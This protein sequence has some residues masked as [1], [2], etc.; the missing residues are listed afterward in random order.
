MNAD[1]QKET[2]VRGGAALFLAIHF[3][4]AVSSF[5]AVEERLRTEIKQVMDMS[6]FCLD[7]EFHAKRSARRPIPE[8]SESGRH[9]LRWMLYVGLLDAVS[10]TTRFN[11]SRRTRCTP[12]ERCSDI[13]RKMK[14]RIE[15]VQNAQQCGCCNELATD[16][17]VPLNRATAYARQYELGLGFDTQNCRHAIATPLPRHT[18]WHGPT[19]RQ[20]QRQVNCNVPLE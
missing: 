3:S 20:S 18:L 10:S 12:T 15:T 16:V 1:L 14:M 13:E 17:G 8:R 19:V 2:K 7:R 6:W 11:N 4:V 5:Q 9:Q